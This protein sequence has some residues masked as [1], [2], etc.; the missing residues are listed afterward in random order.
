M[1]DEQQNT[2]KGRGLAGTPI[3]ARVGVQVQPTVAPTPIESSLLAY[4]PMVD[5][6]FISLATQIAS[7]LADALGKLRRTHQVIRFQPVGRLPQGNYND[8]GRAL[9]Q[10]G[11]MLPELRELEAVLVFGVP[12]TNQ[13]LRVFQQALQTE[14]PD[15]QVQFS[16]ASNTI[17]AIKGPS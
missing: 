2:K 15:F 1:R 7:L 16:G 13:S 12:T 11:T 17:N 3:P 9:T 10:Q 14:L 5:A 6:S 8:K 4:F